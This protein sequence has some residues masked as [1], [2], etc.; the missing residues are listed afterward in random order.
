MIPF[1]THYSDVASDRQ[2]VRSYG[3][4]TSIFPIFYLA[5]SLAFFLTFCLTYYPANILA[6]ILSST[7]LRLW[8]VFGS[9]RAHYIRNW[10]RRKRGGQP[11]GGG[12]LAP[13][14]ISRIF[15]PGKWRTRLNRSFRC[16]NTRPIECTLDGHT[17]GTLSVHNL[18]QQT[19]ERSAYTPQ[20]CCTTFS[21]VHRGWRSFRRSL[22]SK[23]YC[24]VWEASSKPCTR[25]AQ[26]HDGC[27]WPVDS[28]QQDPNAIL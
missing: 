16:F 9:R 1:Q 13:V 21:L 7:L 11:A 22:T 8:H 23:K 4:C 14:S 19:V 2:T 5:S 12:G 20:H 17:C 24:L 28:S 26:W 18:L 3:I 15:S 25:S 27:E 10:Q 6:G